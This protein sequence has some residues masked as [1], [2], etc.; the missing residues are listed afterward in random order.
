M[1]MSE[2]ELADFRRM[3]NITPVERQASQ[4]KII[5]EEMRGFRGRVK[6]KIVWFKCDVCKKET[7]QNWR[8]FQRYRGHCCSR[9]C[10]DIFRKRNIK[11]VRRT[12]GNK[13]N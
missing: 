5:K 10:T 7:K 8:Y 4:T 12:N 2:S 3:H 9:T 11:K 6:I 1:E 13:C